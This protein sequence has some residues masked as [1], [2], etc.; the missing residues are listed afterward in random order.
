MSALA[1]PAPLGATIVP[2]GRVRFRVFAPRVSRLEVET[3]A[4]AR[5]PMERDADGYFDAV[6]PGTAGMRYR[7]RLDGDRE[8]PD[9][10]ARSL[11]EGVHG[12]AEV[13]DPSAFSWT[14]EGWK[15]VPLADYVVYELHVGT[16]TREG[17]FDA[18]IPRLAALRDLGVTA[19]EVMPIASFPGTRNWGYDG[20]GLYAPQA[21][22]GGPGG[23]ARLVD[24]AHAA[25][26]AVVLDVVYNH[27][28]P[29]G[30]YLSD[31]GPYFTDRHK[32]PWGD[33]VNFDGSDAGPIR[34]FFVEN[35][36][37]WVTEF[38]VDALRLDAI[39]GIID[40]SPVHV[41]REMNDAVQRAARR[42]GRVVPL[43]AE[44][45]LNDRRVIDSPSAGGYGLAAQ[46]SDDFHHALHALATGETSGY[47]AD[48]G[49]VDDLARALT[50]GFVYTGQPSRFRGRPHGTPSRDLPGDRFVVFSQ[51][52]DQ[53]GNRAR[54]ERLTALVPFAALKPIAA[55]YL[56]APALPLIFMG[57]EYGEPRP[58]LYFTSH[59]DRALAESVSKGRREEFASFGWSGEVPDPQAESTFERSVLSWDLVEQEPHARLREWYHALLAIRRERPAL[60][61]RGK[62]HTVVRAIGERGLAVMRRAGRDAAIVLLNLG[63]ANLPARLDLPG[64]ALGLALDS[65]DPRFGGQGA[66]AP[67]TLTGGLDAELPAHTAWVYTRRSR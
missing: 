39:H 34:R 13:V 53:V 48:F 20:V 26:L 10:A 35:A 21:S 28:G 24:A 63:E 30:N 44:S 11:P 49:R 9:P 66:M 61:A 56:L 18:A 57:E 25:G 22:Y 58:F 55:A 42:L 50:D 38:H 31:F 41:L 51:N 67:A 45:D 52:H 5:I 36:V 15:G 14:D 37:R 27:L 40:E 64:G 19:I 4:G 16:F 29:E 46:W 65:G 1:A 47:Y 62:E 8:R 7:L 6:A 60:S 12:P 23:F 17:T 3:D 2:D 43:I 32:T 59:G 33:A 54:G